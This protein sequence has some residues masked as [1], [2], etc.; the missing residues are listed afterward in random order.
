MQKT[1]KKKIVLVISRTKVTKQE[2]RSN[3]ALNLQ[4]IGW[5]CEKIIHV[6]MA[7]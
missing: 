4:M 2:I 3:G 6:K 1:K 5:N 7:S